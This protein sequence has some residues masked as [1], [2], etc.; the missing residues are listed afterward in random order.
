MSDKKFWWIMVPVCVTVLCAFSFAL[1]DG[2][3][4]Q[5]AINAVQYLEKV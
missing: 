2:I 4:A 5:R 1:H 3:K